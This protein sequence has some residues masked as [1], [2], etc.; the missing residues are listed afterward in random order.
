MAVT[1]P[2]H[3]GAK[4][5]EAKR[6]EIDRAHG[7]GCWLGF[8]PSINNAPDILSKMKKLCQV[9]TVSTVCFSFL[10]SL[11]SS[12]KCTGTPWQRLRGTP[13]KLRPKES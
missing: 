2:L 11:S 7:Q 5:P 13:W 3:Y 12:C 1:I 9:H 4:I 6:Q 8:T 10:D